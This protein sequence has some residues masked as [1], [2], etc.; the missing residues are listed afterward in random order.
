MAA[1]VLPLADSSSWTVALGCWHCDAVE[2]WVR[3]PRRMGADSRGVRRFGG[4]QR[5]GASVVDDEAWCE[6]A[7]KE[8]KEDE[9][10]KKVR[11]SIE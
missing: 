5:E 1:L 10:E 4:P 6:A 3:D 2:A 7:R 8:E 11:R 9:E